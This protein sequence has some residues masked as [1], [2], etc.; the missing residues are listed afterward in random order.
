VHVLGGA[1]PGL[2]LWGGGR[3]TV[4]RRGR[5]RRRAGTLGLC[6]LSC[7][8]L[9]GEGG[10]LPLHCSGP[11]TAGGSH[12]GCA[13]LPP[14]C[15]GS[16]PA[17][18]PLLHYCLPP[19]SGLFVCCYVGLIPSYT[20]FMAVPSLAADCRARVLVSGGRIYSVALSFVQF[21]FSCMSL[22]SICPLFVALFAFY[23]LL[24]LL[25]FTFG[26]AF[27]Y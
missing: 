16:L 12:L 13:F 18:F 21:F 17:A 5:R 1:V 27:H 19:F 15:Y 9:S 10:G 25:F 26:S 22:V 23:S 7:S 4:R 24:P 6:S 8:L 14:P 11:L 2:V 20:S 3:A